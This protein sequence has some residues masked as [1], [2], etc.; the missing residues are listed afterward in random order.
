MISI[1]PKGEKDKRYLSN[2]RPLCLLNSYYKLISGAISERIKPTLDT[3]INGDQKGF[4]EGRYIGEV[5]RTTYD[6]IQYAK[7]FNKTGLLLLIDFEKAY[8]SISFKFINKT[9]QSFNFGEDLIK[10]VNILLN[11]F[12]AVINHCGNISETFVISRGCR[13]GDPI[14][15]YLF[16]LSIE[17]LAHR[18]RKDELVKGFEIGGFSHLL[19]IYAADLTIFLS[20]CANSLRRIVETLEEFHRIS[21][22]K[23][24]VTKTKA[25]WFGQNYNSNVKLC[26]DLALK[27]EKTFNLLGINF[28]NNLEQ[29]ETNF[30]TKIE[31]IERLLVL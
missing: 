2:W 24:S 23:I 29:M 10:W 27:W 31:S 14:A 25:V 1:I 13:Q 3:L 7:K 9:L 4:V 18:L 11:D 22:L 5:I 6:I 19:E 12:K 20:P 26:P 30:T 8:D 17:I 21:G 28:H 15:C 16:I